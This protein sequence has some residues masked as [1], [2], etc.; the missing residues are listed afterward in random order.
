MNWY[1]NINEKAF[2]ATSGYVSF[3]NGGGSGPLGIGAYMNSDA[4]NG[5]FKYEP[6]STESG[7]YDWDKMAAINASDA[8]SVS[9]EDTTWY[10]AGQAKHIIRNS[11]NNHLWY[12]I[13]SNLRYTFNDNLKLTAGIDSRFYVGEHYREV[14]DLVGGDYWDD[15]VFGQTT[16]GDKIA[17]WNDGIV[18]YSGI[19]AQLEYTNGNLAAFVS[20]TLSN[21]WTKRVDYYSYAENTPID[22]QTAIDTK[23][24]SETLSNFGYNFKA[25][26][27]YNINEKNNV[28]V[29]GGL[30]SRVPFFRFHFLNY[31]NDVNPDL[32]NE[33]I[34]AVELG[35]GLTLR[36][37]KMNVDLYY[38]IWD[39]I[40]V[41][42]GFIDDNGNYVNAFMSD[43]QEIHYG[44]EVEPRYAITNWVQVGGILGIGNWYYGND[45]VAVLYDDLTHEKVGEGTIY[46]KDLKVPDQPQTQIGLNADFRIAKR[47]D[48]G[49]QWLFYDNLYASFTPESRKDENDRAQSWQLPSYSVMNFR[50]G[51]AFK[52]AGLD[53]YFNINCYNV[54]NSEYL[55]EAEDKTIENADGSF[56]HTFKK[57]FWGWGRNFNFSLKL[58]F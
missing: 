19:F 54:F 52:L 4:G 34:Y 41:L 31:M 55:V 45:A 57:G 44:I 9:G 50:A 53:S 22:E 7:Y 58:N 12:G 5:Y 47:I 27:N 56:D 36:K 30:Y 28:Y 26:V 11:V 42:T 20:G 18:T 29:N 6:P 35:Y 25:G 14:R 21:T 3:G 17:Y 51:W 32:Q 37:F 2:L 16:V 40:S 23:N 48:L 8:Y 1:W 10:P 33:K 43:L 46:T 38:S 13:L 15:R 49:A 24:V 39:D